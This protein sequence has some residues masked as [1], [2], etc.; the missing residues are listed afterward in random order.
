[1]NEF[2]SITRAF[3]EKEMEEETPIKVKVTVEVTLD[4]FRSSY[5]YNSETDSNRTDEELAALTN[6]QIM[7]L[8]RQSLI[9]GDLGL[10]D[11]LL[12]G[13]VDIEDGVKWELIND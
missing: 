2:G 7:E 1:V 13:D 8:E 12:S 11:L 10:D 3:K 9:D 6:T 5:K 4:V